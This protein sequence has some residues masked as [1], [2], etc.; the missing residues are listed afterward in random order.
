[1]ALEELQLFLT[2]FDATEDV[3]LQL[4]QSLTN[5]W[6]Q[7]D[8]GLVPD[9]LLE[10]AEDLWNEWDEGVFEDLCGHAKLLELLLHLA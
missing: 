5:Y 7:L 10:T 9:L 6:M 1:M 8:C 4:A 3:P 2:V